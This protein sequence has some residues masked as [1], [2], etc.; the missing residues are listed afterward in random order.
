[1]SRRAGPRAAVLLATLFAVAWASGEG[2]SNLAV[3]LSPPAF[4][5]EVAPLLVGVSP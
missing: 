2:R 4:G 1:M 5:T 3:A